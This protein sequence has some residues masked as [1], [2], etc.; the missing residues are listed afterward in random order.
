MDVLHWLVVGKYSWVFFGFISMVIAFL[1]AAQRSRECCGIPYMLSISGFAGVGVACWT[2]AVGHLLGDSGAV[3]LGWSAH[4]LGVILGVIAAT[5][6]ALGQ[7]E[8]IRKDSGTSRVWWILAITFGGLVVFF[9]YSAAYILIPRTYQYG[10]LYIC[11]YPTEVGQSEA[12]AAR[13]NVWINGRLRFEDVPAAGIPAVS[14][15]PGRHTVQVGARGY[16]ACSQT[17]RM[18]RPGGEA[19]AYFELRKKSQRAP[20]SP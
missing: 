6:L 18:D 9:A 2:L 16:D 3:A 4:R 17:V 20:S 7:T 19:Y 11:A 1:V 10:A 15:K 14:I 13:V 5:V 12:R 8:G